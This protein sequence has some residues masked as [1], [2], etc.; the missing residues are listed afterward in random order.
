LRASPPRDGFRVMA[1]GDR[2]WAVAA[3]RERH[4]VTLDPATVEALRTLA[5]TYQLASPV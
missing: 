2:E 1:P 3:E 4:G 5:S